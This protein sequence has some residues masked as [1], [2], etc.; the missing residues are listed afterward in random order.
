VLVA[1]FGGGKGDAALP[2]RDESVRM[3]FQLDRSNA[4]NPYSLRQLAA[5]VIFFNVCPWARV[6]RG[7]L[8]LSKTKK[9]TSLVYIA[10]ISLQTHSCNSNQSQVIHVPGVSGPCPNPRHCEAQVQAA[11]LVVRARLAA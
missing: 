6:W 11:A 4:N 5:V 7:V 8:L 2:E 1:C 9:R 3:M 10:I